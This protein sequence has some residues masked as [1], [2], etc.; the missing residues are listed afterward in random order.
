MCN[1]YNATLDWLKLSLKMHE[2]YAEVKFQ[3]LRQ[4]DNI[5]RRLL[6]EIMTI[7]WHRFP[8]WL[9]GKNIQLSQVTMDY[10]RPPHFS[11]YFLM[12]PCEVIFN[13]DIV[14]LK[15]KREYLEL[16][17]VQTEN[18]FLDYLKKVPLNWFSKQVYLPDINKEVI[19]VIENTSEIGSLSIEDVAQ[20]LNMCSRTLR[21]KLDANSTSFQAIK[22]EIRRDISI[23]M[24][25]DKKSL[26]Q[27]AYETNFS[28]VS[29][30]SRAF[31]KWTG[32][33]PSAY[34]K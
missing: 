6:K 13:S 12:Y 32:I 3:W 2:H 4:N 19:A 29:A 26:A 25:I 10:A 8:S 22:D 1:F 5:E 7:L 31:K 30:F 14:S 24:L 9:V 18:T 21:R 15:I 23:A 34:V 20:Q 11:E 28:D 16:P 33:S 27:I 17:I